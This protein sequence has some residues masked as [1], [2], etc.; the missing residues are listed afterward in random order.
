MLTAAPPEVMAPE[1]VC[2]IDAT[3]DGRWWSNGIGCSPRC[4]RWRDGQV[5]AI[6]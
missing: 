3:S 4:G 1:R 5:R 2:E 6:L